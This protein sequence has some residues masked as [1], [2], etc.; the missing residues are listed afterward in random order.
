MIG[1]HV[2]P[3]ERCGNLF[4]Y[5]RCTA[6]FCSTA[7]RNATTKER[8]KDIRARERLLFGGPEELAVE[9]WREERERTVATLPQH[10]PTPGALRR[11]RFVVKEDSD[12][13]REVLAVWEEETQGRVFHG[14]KAG[15]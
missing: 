12:V 14:R 3:C 15:A 11:P 13:D 9:A 7:C 5:E 1:Q 2:K 4:E 10:R 8:E 6:K